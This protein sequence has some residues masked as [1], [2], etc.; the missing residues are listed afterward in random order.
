ME[1][2]FDE[3]DNDVTIVPVLVGHLRQV[4]NNNLVVEG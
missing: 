2:F 3:L 4:A 1:T